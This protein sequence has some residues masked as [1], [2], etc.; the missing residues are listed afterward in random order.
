MTI[1][2]KYWTFQASIV[3]MHSVFVF[4]KVYYHDRLL[5]KNAHV[6][7][8]YLGFKISIKWALAR[9]IRGTFIINL[10]EWYILLKRGIESGL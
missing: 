10:L 3:T 2:L 5:L 1:L 4:F 6:I 8:L 9:K 7:M